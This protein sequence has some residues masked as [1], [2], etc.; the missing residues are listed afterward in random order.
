MRHYGKN[1]EFN[2]I[3]FFKYL[4]HLTSGLPVLPTGQEQRAFP[5]SLTHLAPAPHGLGSHG[6]KD[7]KNIRNFVALL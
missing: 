4:P 1:V 2:N 6:S 7:I 3:D 5:L